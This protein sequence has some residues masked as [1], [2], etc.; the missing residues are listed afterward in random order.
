MATNQSIFRNIWLADDD[1]DDHLVFE[2]AINEVLPGVTLIHFFNGEV[3]L[4]QLEKER[5]DIL[6][7]D[8]N[9]PLMDGTSCLKL[10]RE[11]PQFH[12][13]P[14]VV[15]SVS[16]QPLDITSSYGFG[17]T[18]YLIKPPSH[19]KLVMNLKMLLELDWNNPQ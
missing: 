10:I 12:R 15:Y 17:A 8:I 16:R 9:M 18:L 6:F 13:L 2:D 4:Q 3:V 11:K 5:P 19:E 1:E 7:L 14:I